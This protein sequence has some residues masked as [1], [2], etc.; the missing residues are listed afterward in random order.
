VKGCADYGRDYH[1]KLVLIS[2]LIDLPKVMQKI[3][4]KARSYIQN[5]I[6]FSITSTTAPSSCLS[7]AQRRIFLLTGG[8]E[9]FCNQKVVLKISF[10][11]KV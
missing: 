3:Y 2:F 4:S 1:Q 7:E 6:F 10:V 5:S 11:D 8:D 9:N